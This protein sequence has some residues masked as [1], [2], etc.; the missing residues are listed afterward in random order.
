MRLVDYLLRHPVP[1]NMR[2][3][4]EILVKAVGLSDEDKLVFP[5]GMTLPFESVVPEPVAA[6][7]AKLLGGTP[8]EQQVIAA[9]ER[10]DWNKSKAA[11]LLG[12]DRFLVHRLMKFHGIERKRQRKV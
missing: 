7:G 8:N 2:D 6:P 1:A 5:P 12:C 4:V 11:K 3:I 9:L 10:T